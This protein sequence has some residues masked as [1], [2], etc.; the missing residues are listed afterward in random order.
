MNKKL[1]RLFVV[2][3]VIVLLIVMNMILNRT[4]NTTLESLNQ[5]TQDVLLDFER[6]KQSEKADPIWDGYN[7]SS[8]PI[9]F[10][11]KDSWFNN[12]YTFN[13]DELE[14]LN[15][16][17]STLITNTESSVYRFASTNPATWFLNLPFGNFPSMNQHYHVGSYH[18]VYYTKYTNQDIKQ[19]FNQPEFYPTSFFMHEYAHYSIQ[20]NWPDAADFLQP[21]SVEGQALALLQY[22]IYDALI[23]EM[24]GAGR[25]AV[26]AQLLADWSVV[27]TAR[28]TDNPSYVSDEGVKLTLEGVATY[29]GRE[30]SLRIGQPFHYLTAS[31]GTPATYEM[32][33]SA[34]GDGLMDAS[35]ISNSGLYNTGAVLGDALDTVFPEWQMILNGMTLENPVS[36]YDLIYRFV[37]GQQL[38]GQRLDDLKA[39]YNYDSLLSVSQK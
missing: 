14:G 7:L 31:D 15:T 21:L 25:E 24:N 5:T 9:I 2:G 33:I 37:D 30:A 35:Y 38:H 11:D 4:V 19:A 1:K 22:R 26:L 36:V 17:G 16:I 32:I 13:M 28:S 34:I 23:L 29:I 3:G 39:I 27:Q 6:L 8:A 10:V 18:D 20:R 12:A